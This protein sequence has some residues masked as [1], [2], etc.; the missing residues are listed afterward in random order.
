[1]MMLACF[2]QK[3]LTT[4]T[5]LYEETIPEED[6]TATNSLVFCLALVFTDD[7]L[8]TETDNAVQ[9]AAMLHHSIHGSSRS[10]SHDVEFACLR[11]VMIEDEGQPNYAHVAS[12][13]K[14]VEGKVTFS[15]GSN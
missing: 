1:M 9:N 11:S 14:T 5:V 4:P 8:V 3:L 7:A 12:H 13:H 15:L 6:V 10:F 2:D